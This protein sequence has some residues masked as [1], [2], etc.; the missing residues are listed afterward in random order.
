MLFQGRSLGVGGL[1]RLECGSL[2]LVGLE[3]RV[4]EDMS[5]NRVV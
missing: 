3:A 4:L 1:F 5:E 2:G